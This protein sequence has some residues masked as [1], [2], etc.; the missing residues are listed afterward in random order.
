M[1]F[2]VAGLMQPKWSCE[3]LSRRRAVLRGTMRIRCVVSATPG[4]CR[5]WRCG[6]GCGVAE[7]WGHDRACR[8]PLASQLHRLDPQLK[9][10]I[11]TRAIARTFVGQNCRWHRAPL[12][13]GYGFITDLNSENTLIQRLPTFRLRFDIDDNHLN[14]LSEK[15][16]PSFGR[17]G[18][19]RKINF[20]D[21]FLWDPSIELE[22]T[23]VSMSEL[24]GESNPK[25]LALLQDTGRKRKVSIERAIEIL[26]TLESISF[27]LADEFRK[28]LGGEESSVANL[29]FWTCYIYS[30]SIKPGGNWPPKLSALGQHFIEIEHALKE[31]TLA[32]QQDDMARCADLIENSPVLAACLWPE[33]ISKLR[34]ATTVEDVTGAR[35]MV[36]LELFLSYMAC[37]DAQTQADGYAEQSIFSDLFPDFSAEKIKQPN[38]IFF[39][40]LETYTGTKHKLA[41]RMHQISKPASDTD[42]GSTKRQLRRWKSGAGFPSWDVCD[43]LFRNL[44]GDEAMEKDSPRRKDWTVSWSKVMATKRI[45]F[46]MPILAPLSQVRGTYLPFGHETV[47]EWREI[48]YQHWYRHWLPRLDKRS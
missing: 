42:I 9:A 15:K 43:A 41:S 36:M 14:V 29:G 16:P 22:L 17:S 48:R 44:Y 21:L 6:S 13:A 47:Q 31:P 11:Q 5:A 8:R 33:V 10:V 37:W 1:A 30:Q 34:S 28:A 45:N 27:P 3:T 12:T 20:S 39:D 4:L 18:R 23:G 46:L 19:P 26:A 35:L 7:I 2:R 24:F 25:M 40:W 32:W 38:A